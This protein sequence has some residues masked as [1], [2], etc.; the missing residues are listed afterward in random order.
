MVGYIGANDSHPCFISKKLFFQRMTKNTEIKSK[1][2]LETNFLLNTSCCSMPSKYRTIQ[3]SMPLG[4]QNT[5]V[6]QNN[7]E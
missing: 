6:G 7:T 3:R 5:Q 2:I 1:S 4:N